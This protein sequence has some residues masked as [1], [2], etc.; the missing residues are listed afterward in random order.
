MIKAVQ[1]ITESQQWNSQLTPSASFLQS[2]E[3]GEFQRAYGREVVRLKITADDGTSVFAQCIRMPLPLGRSY[4][5]CPR[6][7]VGEG[8]EARIWNVEFRERLTSALKET[9][10]D[11]TFVRVEPTMSSASHA[12]PSSKFYILNSIFSSPPVHPSHTR[13]LDLTQTPDAL[14]AAMHE[15]TRYNIRLS[16]KKNVHAGVE[17]SDAAFAKFWRL[18]KETAER[19]KIRLHGEGYYRQMVAALRRETSSGPTTCWLQMY[20][21][22]YHTTPLAAALVLYFGD[23]ATYVHGASSMA[24]R[25]VM[26]PYALHWRI[27]RDAQEM[28]YQKYD[29]FGINPENPRDRAYK[30]SW[31]GITR[32]KAGFGGKMVSYPGTFDLP[33]SK[34]GYRMYAIGKRLRS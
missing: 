9:Y 12:T 31:E 22:H 11:A 4:W 18:E 3:W 30:K 15:K 32:F 17:Q 8:G 6:G 21:A 2:F 7:P 20:I 24:Y 27:I 23:T 5:F 25:E 14:L 10:S 28:G 33:I 34:W 16:E 26:A 1:S 13:I 19:Q 29:F